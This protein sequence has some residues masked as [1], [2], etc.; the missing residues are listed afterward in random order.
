MVTFFPR[1][2]SRLMSLFV[3]R[4]STCA[5]PTRPSSSRACMLWNSRTSAPSG[6]TISIALAMVHLR[7]ASLGG[8]NDETSHRQAGLHPQVGVEN[9]GRQ[10]R[11][12]EQPLDVAACMTV[13]A[14]KLEV[15][16]GYSLAD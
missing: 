3:L 11:V 1:M 8:T 7:G 15:V 5:S 16:I 9:I 10:T 14:V 4:R 2:S 12:S 6:V 13:A